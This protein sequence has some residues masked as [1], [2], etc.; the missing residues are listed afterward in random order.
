MLIS[1]HGLPQFGS[2]KKPM[3]AEALVLW[4]IDTIDSKFRVLG[5]ELAKTK[6]DEFTEAI[7]VLDRSKIYKI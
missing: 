7:G 6:S 5:E 3:T 1:H 2:P 4:Y